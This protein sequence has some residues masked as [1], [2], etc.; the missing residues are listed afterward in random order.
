[1]AASPAPPEP[2]LTVAVPTCNGSAHLGE[3]IRGILA[4]EGV[5]FELIISDDRSDDETLDVVR[6][7][8]GERARIAVNPQR[9]GLASNW[10]RCVALSRS[11]IVAVFH[12]DDVMEPGHLAAHVRSFA[13]DDRIGLVASASK[14]IDERGQPVPE[15]RVG[16]GGLGPIDRVF[17]PGELAAAMLDGNPLR[18]SAVTLRRAA[19]DDV[20]GFDGSYRYALDWDFWL[21]VSRRWKVAWLWRPTVRVRWHE[22]SETHRFKTGMADLDETARFIE[23]LFAIDLKDRPDAGTLRRSANGRLARAFLNRAHDALRAGRTELARQ[24]LGRGLG[25]S[26]SLIGTIVRDPRLGIPMAALAASPRLAGR[27]FGPR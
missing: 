19:F 26:P 12:Q 4:Q 24:A 16:R 21:R 20:G 6:A 3:A 14:V 7:T 10:N 15:S 27:M 25:L 8:A 13:A 23:E 1:V 18:C 17:E 9:L 5:A 22:A 2:I 11:P